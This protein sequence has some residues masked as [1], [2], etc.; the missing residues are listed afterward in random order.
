MKYAAQMRKILIALLLVPLFSYSQEKEIKNGTY[1]STRQTEKLK[2][3]LLDGNKYEL[4]FLYGNYEKKGDTLFL[5]NQVGKKSYFSAKFHSDA[6]ISNKV[7]V[8]IKNKY[9]TTYMAQIYVGT[10]DGS[11]PVQ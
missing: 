8:K 11:L 2:L 1:I 6:G 3:N 9:I 5:G 7:A 10:Q 4:V